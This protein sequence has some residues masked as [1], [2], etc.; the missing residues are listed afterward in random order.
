MEE[1]TYKLKKQSFRPL[2]IP[3]G[4][5]LH[6]ETSP[7]EMIVATSPRYQS[8]PIVVT[9]NSARIVK[10]VNM[11]SLRRSS[12]AVSVSQ[13]G[14]LKERMRG[15]LN[16]FMDSQEGTKSATNNNMMKLNPDHFFTKQ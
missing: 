12:A 14:S 8:N 5:A 6:I 7:R 3:K 16:N 4:P 11:H 1:K 10:Q 9:P 13:Q 15:I 2:I